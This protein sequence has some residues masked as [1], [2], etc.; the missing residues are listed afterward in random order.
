MASETHNKKLREEIDDN[1]M[2]ASSA[3]NSS[4]NRRDSLSLK[5]LLNSQIDNLKEKLSKSQQDLNLAENQLMALTRSS[6]REIDQLRE[7]AQE[8]LEAQEN[9]QTVIAQ[10]D[11]LQSELD[12]KVIALEN[13]QNEVRQIQLQLFEEQSKSTVKT[14]QNQDQEMSVSELD[15]EVETPNSKSSISKSSNSKLLAEVSRLMAMI[16][17][18]RA[19][20]DENLGRAHFSE[21]EL[22]FSQELHQKDVAKLESDLANHVET[23][24]ELT[25]A[26][27]VARITSNEHEHHIEKLR[28]DIEQ[29]KHEASE[30]VESLERALGESKVKVNDRE[31]VE[32]SLLIKLDGA[33]SQYQD[34]QKT[35][36]ETKARVIEL[37]TELIA[38]KEEAQEAKEDLQDWQE[39][40]LTL[41]EG[42][43]GTIEK[44][45]ERLDESRDKHRSLEVN[46]VVLQDS[47]KA[48]LEEAEKERLQ[49]EQ[50]IDEISHKF[51]Q[52]LESEHERA[53]FTDSRLTQLTEM[54]NTLRENFNNTRLKH[55]EEIRKLRDEHAIELS[56]MRDSH[57][58]GVEDRNRQVENALQLHEDHYERLLNDTKN[59]LKNIVKERDDLLHQLRQH[60]EHLEEIRAEFVAQIENVKREKQEALDDACRKFDE[61]LIEVERRSV[62]ANAN[63]DVLGETML[64]D[65]QHKAEYHE[66]EI[67]YE[68]RISKLM[69]EI[70]TANNRIHELENTDIPQSHDT[71]AAETTAGNS[72]LKNFFDQNMEQSE[73]LPTTEQTMNS[74][75]GGVSFNNLFNQSGEKSREVV[76]IN[77]SSDDEQT[78]DV[79]TNTILGRDV[80]PHSENQDVDIS[81]ANESVKDYLTDSVL[82]NEVLAQSEHGLA[83]IQNADNTD[84]SFAHLFA[85]HQPTYEELKNRISELE[86]QLAEAIMERDEKLNR[87]LEESEQRI[88]IL[89][90]EFKKAEIENNN[91]SDAKNDHEE[92]ERLRAMVEVIFVNKTNCRLATQRVAELEQQLVEIS[93][94]RV[95]LSAEIDNIKSQR[96]LEVQSENQQRVLYENEL[97]QL[98]QDRQNDGFKLEEVT[99]LLDKITREYEFKQDELRKLI[100]SHDVDVENQTQLIENSK[101]QVDEL[102]RLLEESQARL[103]GVEEDRQNA[104]NVAYNELQEVHKE[105]L[106]E[107]SLLK[108]EREQFDQQLDS[109]TK[110]I[111]EHRGGYRIVNFDF[112]NK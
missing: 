27:K 22:K 12:K 5:E 14:K 46:H 3:L 83:S 50:K 16:H 20:R 15:N 86:Q 59:E 88:R 112:T 48:L 107:L 98:R 18:L 53:R 21:T 42:A 95:E 7:Q 100:D 23:Q 25:E 30:K 4:T 36:S 13:A 39:H 68:Q 11:N 61:R 76:E 74:S 28:I 99:T 34:L 101:Q 80:A 72:T 58:N 41:Q 84:V 89:Y 106:R 55:S 47:N 32:T 60:D 91:A 62:E 110:L 66:M 49:Y 82:G 67:Q 31:S 109:S 2:A 87:A 44:L 71:S 51:D 29:L 8:G 90:E 6:K 75:V 92:K 33:T 70:N 35:L 24:N 9:L 52:A 93:N 65:A 111:Q 108:E 103:K 94:H 63:E 26:L 38:S 57:E 43:A 1:T 19:D 10:S 96:E 37:D 97:E 104:D 79:S 40:R 85:D 17:R 102:T 81:M 64:D 54:S 45:Q 56:N 78:P 73:I 77:D 105:L 69:E